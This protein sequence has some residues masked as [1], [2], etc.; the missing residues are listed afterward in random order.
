MTLRLSKCC[1]CG[2]PC[3]GD[4]KYKARKNK[5]YIFCTFHFNYYVKTPMKEMR[6]KIKLNKY[7]VTK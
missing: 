7:A 5:L 3:T 2:E 6:K 4:M 1:I